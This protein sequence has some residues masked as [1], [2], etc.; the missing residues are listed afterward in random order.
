[1]PRGRLNIAEQPFFVKIRGWHLAEPAEAPV[2]PWFS[3]F[4]TPLSQ[5]QPPHTIGRRRVCAANSYPEFPLEP[6][7]HRR[8][9]TMPANGSFPRFPCLESGHSAFG[10]LRS[11]DTRAEC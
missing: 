9:G 4:K 1:M 2:N 6:A 5:D 11:C 3:S 8:S 10:Q 7:A